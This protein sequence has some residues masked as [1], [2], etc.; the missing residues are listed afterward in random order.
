MS[1]RKIKDIIDLETNELVYP[2][3]HAKATYMSDG[4]TVEEAINNLS[5]NAGGNGINIVATED[6]LDENAPAGTLSCVATPG[7][8]EAISAKDLYQPTINDIDMNTFT[9]ITSGFNAVSNIEI[10]L[11]SPEVE[12]VET[13]IYFCT[14]N[15]P[16]G[17]GG[18]G[19]V[20]AIFTAPTDNYISAVGGAYINVGTQ[21]QQEFLFYQVENSSVTVHQEQIDTFMGLF[22]GY[23]LYYLGNFE[24]LMNGQT[25]T[26][27]EL[28][29]IDKIVQISSGIK[30][31]AEL[32]LK[33]D[34]WEKQSLEFKLNDNILP[35]RNGV[36]DLGFNRKK[37]VEVT[38]SWMQISPNILY[39]YVG[40]STSPYFYFNA[41]NTGTVVDEYMVE[42]TIPA[43]TNMSISFP[44]S[45][46]WANGLAPVFEPGYTYQ[47]S[48]VN[49]LGTYVKFIKV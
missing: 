29:T 14:E 25:I 2:K 15:T 17:G 30:S 27:E 23:E 28:E 44:S 39:R 47:F 9:I 7:T 36:V 12:G 13:M 20:F 4:I 6:D 32:F 46:I 11:D 35:I 19:V 48:I 8:I 34:K 16:I 21:E 43:N 3:A 41:T 5:L 10:S 31:T 1:I 26:P 45:V 42:L 38:D 37:I 40:T 22:N 33:K 18:D 49:N 24:K